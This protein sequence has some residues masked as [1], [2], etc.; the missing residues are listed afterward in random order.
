LYKW[1]TLP[2]TIVFFLNGLGHLYYGHKLKKKFPKYHN[3]YDTL[4]L[5]CLW[6]AAGVFYPL[7]YLDNNVFL[8]GYLN[9]CTFFICIFTPFMVWLILYYQKRKIK[10][11]PTIR[12]RRTIDNFIEKNEIILNNNTHSLKTDLTRKL[13]HLFP[14]LMI[15]FLWMFAINIWGGLWNQ[16]PNWGISAEDFGRILILTVG[17]SGILIFAALDY[18]RLSPLLFNRSLFHLLPDNVSNLLGKAI[19]GEELYEFTKPATLILAFATI[20][21]FPFPVFFAA[22]LIATIGDGAASI[23][24]K[25]FGKKHFPKNSPKTIIGYIS[26]FLGSFGVALLSFIIFS[27]GILI[28]KSIIIS[29]VGALVFLI[30]DLLTVEL[31]DNIL[32]PIFSAF[33]MNFLFIIL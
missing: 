11:N 3:F 15:M 21:F 12:E 24:G 16:G 20:F 4:M 27:Q 18:V 26:G 14:A 17:Y 6:F 25:R 2:V 28:I 10:K 9:I 8:E 22:A 31:D 29:F 7:Y 32:N 23:M 33:F 1:N 13:L 19:K 30:I 5:A